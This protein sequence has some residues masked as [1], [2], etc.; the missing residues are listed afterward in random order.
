[1]QT[2]DKQPDCFGILWDDAAQECVKCSISSYCQRS[3]KKREDGTPPEEPEVPPAEAT[4]SE[5]QEPTN[6]LDYFLQSLEGRYDRED[7]VGE[8][9][10]GHFF[11]ENGNNAILVT[12][13]KASGRLKVQTTK[14]YE[15]ILDSI[16]SIEQ[17]EE[18]LKD[19]LG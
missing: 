13:S 15:R 9:A 17:A 1:M 5:P 4:E 12:E 16:Q 7:K 14:G 2:T 18:I 19:I 11:R 8:N 6:P 10:I 3:M